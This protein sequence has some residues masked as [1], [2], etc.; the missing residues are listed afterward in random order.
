MMKTHKL[1]II[2]FACLFAFMLP[3]YILFI[4]PLLANEEE[5]TPVNDRTPMFPQVTR[6]EIQSIEVFN[7]YGSYKF[8][9][10]SSNNFCL[11]GFPGLMYDQ[12]QFAYLVTATGTT[13]T[14]MKVVDNATEEDLREYGLDTP[15]AHWVLTTTSGDVHTV[16]V[17]DNLITEGGYYAQY[18]GR[19]SIYIISNLI[20]STILQPAEKLI[21][22]YL[23]TGLMSSN[24]YFYATNFT[25]WRNNELFLRIYNVPTEEMADPEAIVETKM[26]FP[27]G[28]KPNDNNYFEMLYAMMTLQGT[29]TVKIGTNSEILDEYGL[30][31][32]AYSVY[33]VFSNVEVYLYFSEKQEDDTYYVTSN[34]SNK[35]MITK[36]DASSVS[37]LEQDLNYWIDE[38]PFMVN[39]GTVSSLDVKADGLDLTFTH[40]H[41]YDEHGNKTLEAD[42][43]V[44]AAKETQAPTKI[45]LSLEEIYT[46][47]Q[48]FR[49]LLS[50]KIQGT[51]SLT[52][53]EKA[54]LIADDSKLIFTFSY[55]NL[56]GQVT[57]YK[58]HQYSTRHVLITINGQGE[59]YTHVD[60]L[61]KAASNA[62]KVLQVI[63]I[64]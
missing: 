62:E 57:E 17:G 24:D 41:G 15:I 27:Q 34:L 64:D 20:E 38:N 47:K 44:R 11:E 33:Y 60:F 4:R 48:F 36:I 35:Q 49:S 10:D 54:A 25:I 37:W 2:V 9:R 19:N 26:Y 63:D 53:E 32:P 52:D 55:T 45:H 29:E 42:I 5:K 43:D 13:S 46:Y 8:Y 14:M 1:L 23:T 7:E 40:I 61:T 28:Y 51:D 16:Y 21:A 39:I 12:N 31:T 18:E 3:S 6:D 59:F 22:P 58:F 50:I 30:L 56:A